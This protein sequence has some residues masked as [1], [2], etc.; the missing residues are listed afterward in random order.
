MKMIVTLAGG[1]LAAGAA[2]ALPTPSH[3]YEFSG[4]LKEARGG[5]AAV[6]PNAP[7]YVGDGPARGLAFGGNQ[8]PALSNIFDNPA[9]YTIEMFFEIDFT[10]SYRKLIDFKNR[11]SDNGLYVNGGTLSLLGT[12][13]ARGTVTP[14]SFTHLVLTRDASTKQTVAYLNGVQAFSV[15]DS[16]NAATFSAAGGIAHFLRDDIRGGGAENSPGTLDFIRIYQ[17]PSGAA[18]VAALYN[19]GNPVRIAGVP[20]PAS[21]AMMIAGFGLAGTAARRRRPVAMA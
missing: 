19:N 8:G 13:G 5:P 18:D 14:N 11:A 10:S 16:N 12:G 1:V 3:V 17:A 6:V 4:S 15:T 21:W 20:E 7:A 9:A 2:Q